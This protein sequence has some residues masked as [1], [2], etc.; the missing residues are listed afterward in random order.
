M[1]EGLPTP[2]R[3]QTQAL[4]NR[5]AAAFGAPETARA[6][7]FK[8]LLDEKVGHHSADVLIETADHFIEG[9]KSWPKIADVIA[10]AREA[11][12]LAKARA[13]APKPPPRDPWSPQSVGQ[14]DALVR[15]GL[16]RRAVAQGWAGHLWDFCRR[17]GRRPEG[18]H[19]IS[20]LIA[21]ARAHEKMKALARSRKI[22]GR[23]G[24][25]LA[26]LADGLDAHDRELAE[27]VR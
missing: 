3:P 1:R 13:H 12:A 25:A 22:K 18:G 17:H 21:S 4:I 8:R 9:R 23:L 14:A 7:E 15:C 27:K 24:T 2:I 16:G 11:Q 5:L 26:R 20:H 10:V 19:E 6:A